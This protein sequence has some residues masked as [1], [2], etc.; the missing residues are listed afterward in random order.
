MDPPEA[1]LQN[2]V[3]PGTEEDRSPCNRYRNSANADQVPSGVV[4]Y[5][6][7]VGVRSGAATE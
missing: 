1:V 7:G 3:R 5:F 6:G 4:E 2:E